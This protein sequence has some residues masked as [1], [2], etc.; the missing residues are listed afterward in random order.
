MVWDMF[1][2]EQESA[3]QLISECIGTFILVLVNIAGPLNLILSGVNDP[4]MIN[5]CAAVGVFMGMITAMSN[6]GAHINPMVTTSFVA[7]GRLSWKR[8]PIYL[9][10]QY[11]GAFLA[12]VVVFMNFENALFKFDGG[13]RLFAGGMNATGG[14]F[15][16]APNDASSLLTCSIDTILV[17]FLL[18]FAICGITDKKNSGVPVSL[19]APYVSAVVM[20]L[21]S[22]FSFNCG[23]AMNPA[24]DL[25]PR[26]LTTLVG[27]GVQGFQLRS[28]WFWLIPTF[29]PHVGGL[30]GACTYQIT[31]GIQTPSEEDA[32]VNSKEQLKLMSTR[33]ST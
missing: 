14:P 9:L 3:R 32:Q 16:T 13:V 6:S 31:I 10:A 26:L 29:L 1:I 28:W 11:I 7:I 27:Y 30:L 21:C 24:R 25:S 5:F 33:R 18:M 4:F 12:A 8:A 20:G 22:S 19:Y 15:A 2:V 23:V 17:S